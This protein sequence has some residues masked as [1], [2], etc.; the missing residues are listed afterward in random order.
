MLV[1]LDKFFI[2]E[3]NKAGLDLDY[4]KLKKIYQDSRKTSG[5]I[6]RQKIKEREEEMMQKIAEKIEQKGAMKK[7]PMLPYPTQETDLGHGVEYIIP[8]KDKKH[9]LQKMYPLGGNIGM[10]SKRYDLTA[11]RNF[12]VKDFKVIY[13]DG[14]NYLL[15]PYGGTPLDW[16]PYQKNAD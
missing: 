11:Q 14:L 7:E 3:L 6:Q 1:K 5:C 10:S 15:S 13:E 12:K 4:K 9:I 8:E 16:L 2:E